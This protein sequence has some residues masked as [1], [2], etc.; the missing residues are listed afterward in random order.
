MS[1]IYGGLSGIDMLETEFDFGDG[2]IIRKTYAHLFSSF[3]MAFKPPEKYKHH[4]EP[5]KAAK[6][7]TSFDISAEIEVPSIK[8]LTDDFDQKEL[9]WTIA[10]LLRLAAYPFITIPTISNMSFNE[11]LKSTEEPIITPFETKY[12]IFT[13]KENTKQTISIDNLQWVKSKFKST[14]NLMKK[15]PKFYSAFKAF[16]SAAEVGRASSSLVTVWGAIEQLFSPNTGELKYRVSANLASYLSSH[17]QE[18]LKLFK[19]ISKLYN[20]RSIAAHTSKDLD[21]SPLIA[22]YVHFRNALVKVVEQGDVPSQ[23]DLEKMIFTV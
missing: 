18:R 5:W 9:I 12:R 17:G 21:H 15:E 14:V 10:S 1:S 8:E 19:E 22:T 11:V 7:G 23:D 16:D 6:G 4:E 20:D 3:M 13:V 2:I